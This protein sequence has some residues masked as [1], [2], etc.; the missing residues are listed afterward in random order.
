MISKF[1]RTAFILNYNIFH[2]VKVFSV[3][4]D[5]F[6]ASLLIKSSNFLNNNK[7]SY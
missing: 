7:K 1:K 6:K 4:F 2:N 5:Q 3:S